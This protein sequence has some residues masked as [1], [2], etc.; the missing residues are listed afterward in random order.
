MTFPL[1][2]GII[3]AALTMSG[4]VPQIARMYRTKSVA[5]I[6]VGTLVQ[7][8]LGVT[9]WAVYGFSVSDPILIGAS[10]V[11]LLPLVVALGLYFHY[12]HIHRAPDIAREDLIPM[13]FYGPGTEIV[14]LFHTGWGMIS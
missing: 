5:D 4:F 3:A 10:S 12:Q 11:S 8:T 1:F 2:I 7:F 6:S 14:A 9:L 13:D